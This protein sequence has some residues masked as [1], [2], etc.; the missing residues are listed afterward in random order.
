MAALADW[1]RAQDPGQ[2]LAEEGGL[3]SLIVPAVAT[4][5]SL[6]AARRAIEGLAGQGGLARG[7]AFVVLNMVHGCFGH[8]E[9][10]PD[11]LWLSA[12]A[13]ARRLGFVVLPRCEGE[14]LP[15]VEA[16][17]LSL[18]EAFAI[19][20]ADF[21]VRARISTLRAMWALR[22]FAAF[23]LV[24]LD[25]FAAAGFV[26]RP[27]RERA[28]FEALDA[29]WV[30]AA[31]SARIEL[32]GRVEAQVA[33]R[34]GVAPRELMRGVG[35]GDERMLIEVFPDLMKGIMTEVALARR[36][37]EVPDFVAQR[38]GLEA[39]L[40]AVRQRRRSTKSGIEPRLGGLRRDVVVEA[41]SRGLD[42][43]DHRV[44]SVSYVRDLEDAGWRALPRA[45]AFLGRYH[46][47]TLFLSVGLLKARSP[48]PRL[49]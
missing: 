2:L 20:P 35:D 40:E 5:T 41:A 43:T 21:A 8:L 15:M 19:A 18:V 4:R 42:V 24:A 16:G 33:G 36:R 49:H 22:G 14:V 12:E 10:D 25:A 9:D 28:R 11:Y 1:S 7:R 37:D 23:A 44:A 3:P 26:P 13:E 27:V 48:V 6:S 45:L 47:E 32:L 38:R 17:G 30:E 39:A 34:V 29:A 46:V 31:A